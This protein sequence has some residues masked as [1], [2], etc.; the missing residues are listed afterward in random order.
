MQTRWIDG[1]RMARIGGGGL[2]AISGVDFDDAD[3]ASNAW[4]NSQ[5]AYTS[6][7]SNGATWGVTLA[8]QNLF[9]R[10]PPI[11]PS[12]GSR[13]GSQTVSDAYDAE[14]RRYNLSVNYS[15]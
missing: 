7:T 15:F 4:V 3:I 14:G 6:E 9:N 11:I 2:L 8:V 1:V 5:L 10:N 13:G 12:F